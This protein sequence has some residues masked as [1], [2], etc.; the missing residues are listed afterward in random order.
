MSLVHQAV[1]YADLNVW[2]VNHTLLSPIYDCL[3]SLLLGQSTFAML[4][5]S[6]SDLSIDHSLFIQSS[7]Q[8][9]GSIKQIF[10]ALQN[11][12]HQV[13]LAES[14]FPVFIFCCIDDVIVFFKGSILR[15]G[16]KFK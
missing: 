16:A 11:V 14:V 4:L 1:D 12:A 13:K 5:G 6:K 3:Q 2:K 15:D 9:I 8:I 7:G 10:P